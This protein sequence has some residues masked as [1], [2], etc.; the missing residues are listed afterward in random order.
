MLREAVTQVVSLLVRGDFE[1]L[2]RLKMLGPASKEEY[3][4]TLR[5]F[6]RERAQLREPPP[7]VFESLDICETAHSGKW[8]VDTDLWTDEGLSDLTATLY[9]HEVEADA[10]HGVLYDLR[11]L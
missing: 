7:Q 11:V 2:D 9:V 10:C 5:R 6:L 4:T 1:E 8:R 3:E